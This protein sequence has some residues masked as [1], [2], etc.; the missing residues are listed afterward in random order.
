[1]APS[2]FDL[3]ERILPG[4]AIIHDASLWEGMLEIPSKFWKSNGDQWAVFFADGDIISQVKIESLK[5]AREI[6]YKP[7][8]IVTEHSQ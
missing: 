8:V 6:S 4:R 2:E 1:M 5:K 7:L 3:L